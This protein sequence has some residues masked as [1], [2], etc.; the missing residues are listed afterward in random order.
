M[1]KGEERNLWHGR[2]AVRVFGEN[3][4]D[5]GFLKTIE[6]KLRSAATSLFDVGRSMFDVRRSSLKKTL[7][8]IIVT[9][10]CLQ[11]K[12]ALMGDEYSQ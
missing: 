10:E 3:H 7:Y 11:K 4:F 5:I 1:G 9:Y 2:I 8:G 12:L 6:I